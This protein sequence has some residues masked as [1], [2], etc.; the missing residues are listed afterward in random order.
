MDGVLGLDD[1][2]PVLGASDTRFQ[3]CACSRSHWNKR[4]QSEIITRKQG[5][6]NTDAATGR[7]Q[8]SCK[9]WVRMMQQQKNDFFT[10][11]N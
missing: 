5:M 6:K 10:E 3:R 9:T 1:L 7:L 11:E 4:D 2:V 8:Q